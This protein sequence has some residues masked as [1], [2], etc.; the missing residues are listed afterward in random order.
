MRSFFCANVRR[1]QPW[2]LSCWEVGAPG[3]LAPR[4]LERA[5]L[6]PPPSPRS[7][8]AF[9]VKSLTACGFVNFVN[10]TFQKRTLGGD[11]YRDPSH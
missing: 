7:C 11:A 6:A 10:L 4:A 8:G 5:L 1:E 3:S 2:R 9:F